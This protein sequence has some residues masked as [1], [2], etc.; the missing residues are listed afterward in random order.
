MTL[1]Q[2]IE[3]LR[4]V[5]PDNMCFDGNNAIVRFG[6]HYE[7]IQTYSDARAALQT[8]IAVSKGESND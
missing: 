3:A 5:V 4:K 7:G 1:E 2:C 8:M 6:G